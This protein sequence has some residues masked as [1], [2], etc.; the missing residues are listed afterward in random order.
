MNTNN[1][2]KWKKIH[3]EQVEAEALRRVLDYLSD[4]KDDYEAQGCPENHI[5][6]DIKKIEMILGR[7][8]I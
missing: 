5:Y 8:N 6:A 7:S 2:P 4:E 1:E 3:R